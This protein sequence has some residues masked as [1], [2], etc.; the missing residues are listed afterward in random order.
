MVD[1]RMIEERLNNDAVYRQQFMQD[2][3]GVLSQEGITLSPRQESLL[4]QEVAKAQIVIVPSRL[5][6]LN[7]SIS[8][9]QTTPYAPTAVKKP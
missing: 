5:A 6:E 7:L 4:R 1:L 9:E 3:V 8:L 2:P